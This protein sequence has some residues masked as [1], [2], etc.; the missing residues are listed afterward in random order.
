MLPSR[1]YD[2]MVV[3]SARTYGRLV[4]RREWSPSA[5]CTNEDDVVRRTAHFVLSLI[6]FRGFLRDLAIDKRHCKGRRPA[7][8]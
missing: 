3:H 2:E 4:G 1:D 7:I 8:C 6:V 5:Q